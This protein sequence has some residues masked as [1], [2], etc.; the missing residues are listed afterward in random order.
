[1]HI[2][3]LQF[4]SCMLGI[5]FCIF[6]LSAIIFQNKLCQKVLSRILSE[7]QTDQAGHFNKTPLQVFIKL[8]GLQI[9]VIIKNYYLFYSQPKH[10]VGTTVSLRQFFWEPRTHDKLMFEKIITVLCVKRFS[11]WAY[12]I[13]NNLG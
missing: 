4:N 3:S 6:L 9:R 11:I 8:A 10:V 1:M 5:K 7:C 2:L 12:E 13:N